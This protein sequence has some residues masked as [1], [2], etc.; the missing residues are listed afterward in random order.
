LIELYKI[1]QNEKEFKSFID[2]MNL[3]LVNLTKQRYNF[4]LKTDTMKRWFLKNKIY[5]KNKG[6]FPTTHKIRLK[7]N[8]LMDCPII[9]FLRTENIT[10]LNDDAIIVYDTYKNESD[11]LLFL[12]PPNLMA[13]YENNNTKQGRCPLRP[14]T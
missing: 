9:H 12:D 1:A 8:D 10:F 14:P 11:A 2:K 4:L 6:S 13:Y 5:S 7:Y 3:L